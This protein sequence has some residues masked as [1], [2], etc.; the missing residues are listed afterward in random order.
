MKIHSRIPK[1][2]LTVSFT[3]TV[4]II[5]ALGVLGFGGTWDAAKAWTKFRN[6][7][8]LRAAPT[9]S[10]RTGPENVK[11][12]NWKLPP[13]YLSTAFVKTHLT[14]SAP[15]TPKAPP[16]TAKP[17]LIKCCVIGGTVGAPV[18]PMIKGAALGGSCAEVNVWLSKSARN[19]MATPSANDRN[20]IETLDITPPLKGLQGDCSVW[21]YHYGN[22]PDKPRGKVPGRVA[23]VSYFLLNVLLDRIVPLL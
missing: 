12:E 21:V 11:S 4:L 2:P 3:V 16:G 22:S 14:H 18:P 1:L 23:E 17:K 9:N 10:T 13:P 6:R 19:A 8:V 15:S 5:G 7:T 20:A